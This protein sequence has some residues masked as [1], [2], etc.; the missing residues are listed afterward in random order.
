MD[1]IREFIDRFERKIIIP[2]IINGVFT[3]RGIVPMRPSKLT[4]TPF[5]RAVGALVDSDL[6]FAISYYEHF[7]K[8]RGLF[9]Q[10][11]A[12]LHAANRSPRFF[13]TYIINF[14]SVKDFQ[15]LEITGGDKHFI[16]D[17]VVMKQIL[18]KMRFGGKK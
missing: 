1:E 6:S 8:S 2:G 16:G 17:F 12:M 10:A 13:Q 15:I 4:S 7:K 9:E 3:K 11:S 5:G 14:A 18:V